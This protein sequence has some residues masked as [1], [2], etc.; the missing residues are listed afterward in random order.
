MSLDTKLPQDVRAKPA[1]DSSVVDTQ[2]SFTAAIS[3]FA[4]SDGASSV[5]TSGLSLS[6]GVGGTSGLLMPRVMLTP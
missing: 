5:R 6:R 2:G 3:I 1:R 4:A